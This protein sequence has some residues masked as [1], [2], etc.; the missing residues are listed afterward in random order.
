[1]MDGMRKTT[2]PNDKFVK[3]IHNFLYASVKC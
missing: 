1:V 3:I 2:S